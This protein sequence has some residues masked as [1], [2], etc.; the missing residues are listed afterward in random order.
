M[1]EQRVRVRVTPGARKEK[2]EKLRDGVFVAAVR[3][4]AERNEA[5]DRVRALI[6]GEYRVPVAAVRIVTGQRGANKVLT[7]KSS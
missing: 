1:S 5:N 3:E 7:I 2:F 6:A 4:K